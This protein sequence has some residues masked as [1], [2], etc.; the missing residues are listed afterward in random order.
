[1]SKTQ[2]VFDQLPERNVVCWSALVAGYA[3]V[4][5]T[6]VVLDIYRRMKSEGVEPNSVTFIVLL[7]ACSHSGLL[8]EGEVLFNEMCAVYHFTPTLEH[9]NCMVSLFGRAGQLNKVK[10][11][12]EKV[13]HSY[14]IPLVSTILGVCN[15]WTDVRLGRCSFEQI[16]QLDKTC[17]A[18]YVTLQN[19]YTTIEM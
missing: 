18:A 16:T 9:Y 6:H 11:L 13:P 5:Q 15:K 19:I 17:V 4:G 8:K 10:A 2:E 1:M 7:A 12:L 3:Q 14:H